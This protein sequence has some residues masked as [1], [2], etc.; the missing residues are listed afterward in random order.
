[1]GRGSARPIFIRMALPVRLAQLAG[2][3]G[4]A[5]LG[6]VHC[7]CVSAAA[8]VVSARTGCLCGLLRARAALRA[9]LV[10]RSRPA[11]AE[12]SATPE[13]LITIAANRTSGPCPSPAGVHCSVGFVP[14]RTGYGLL[15]CYGTSLRD[16]LS[17][18][19]QSLSTKG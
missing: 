16:A 12:Q 4:L 14:A 10:L 7:N 3:L 11:V 6:M 2:P 9:P 17:N 1:M 5:P 8:S 18:Q 15:A 13:A 19:G